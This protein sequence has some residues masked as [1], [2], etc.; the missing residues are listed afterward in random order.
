[1]RKANVSL[2]AWGSSPTAWYMAAML[3][4]SSVISIN[5]KKVPRGLRLLSLDSRRPS[6]RPQSL[7]YTVSSWNF[8]LGSWLHQTLGSLTSRILANS[9]ILEIRTFKK[10]ALAVRE[11]LCRKADIQLLWLQL[12][13]RYLFIKHIYGPTMCQVL[14]EELIKKQISTR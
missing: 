14:L 5:E 9:S 4:S 8:W 1:M 12:S 6:Y 3:L 7:I 10:P 11:S 2:L 13:R